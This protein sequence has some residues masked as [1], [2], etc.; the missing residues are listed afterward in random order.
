MPTTP[1]ITVAAST[2]GNCSSGTR[3]FAWAYQ[4]AA[5]TAVLA[6]AFAAGGP[7]HGRR[8]LGL[9]G[10]DR[11]DA[12]PASIARRASGSARH[13]RERAPVSPSASFVSVYK[14]VPQPCMTPPAAPVGQQPFC[15]TPCPPSVVVLESPCLISATLPFVP[16]TNASLSQ[17]ALTIGT[18]VARGVQA[19]ALALAVTAP[20]LHGR[21]ASS[22]P[23]LL[24]GVR[25]LSLQQW[26][27]PLWVLLRKCATMALHWGFVQWQCLQRRFD[28]TLRTCLLSCVVRPSL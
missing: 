27:P 2:G 23:V 5:V 14:Q 10:R 26:A 16:A 20:P 8:R 15:A 7:A 21:G 4:L 9:Q 22:A 3:L 11:S 25:R 19:E 1:R 13:R 24:P 17:L 28:S 12:P 6:S 18:A